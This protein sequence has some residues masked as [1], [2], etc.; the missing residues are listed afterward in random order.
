MADLEQRTQDTAVQVQPGRRQMAGAA[1]CYCV[2]SWLMVGVMLWRSNLNIS[3]EGVAQYTV[4]MIGMQVGIILLPALIYLMVTGR[5]RQ[6][7]APVRIRDG[8]CA[9]GLAIFGMLPVLLINL[10]W[11]A[12]LMLLKLPGDALALPV[13]EGAGQTMLLAIALAMTPGLCEEF[14]FRGVLLGGLDRA[15]GMKKAIFLSALLFGLAHMNLQQLLVTFLLGLVIGYLYVKTRS[16][17]PGILYHTAHNA[18]M[19]LLYQ[20]VI[21]MA[22]AAPPVAMAMVGQPAGNIEE[23]LAGISQSQMLLIAAAVLLIP[24]A[25]SLAIYLLILR[26]VSRRQPLAPPRPA[27]PEMRMGALSRVLLALGALPA[28]VT[29]AMQ[30]LSR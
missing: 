1:L 24:A 25:I 11:V 2:V 14:M 21:K 8:L 29:L 9:I 22:Q 28:V 7:L 17:W 6:V 30:L 13:A 4:L 12:L 16:I 20:A 23:L 27:Q 19:V 5:L 10:L 18:L 26:G 3:P 15:T